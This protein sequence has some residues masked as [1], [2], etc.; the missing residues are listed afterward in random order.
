[1]L[2]N[3]GFPDIALAG[4]F[5]SGKDM[6]ADYLVSRYWY[7]KFAFGNEL[8]RYAHELFDVDLDAKPRELYQWFGQTMRERDPDI[9]VRKCFALIESEREFYRTFLEEKVRIVVTD[10][11]Q[12]NEYERCKA[13][14]F[15]LI[16]VNAADEI[17]LERAKSAGDQ[18]DEETLNHTTE[19]YVDLFDVDY[20]IDNNGT[21]AELFSQ[22]DGI[23]ADV[24]ADLPR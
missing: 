11:R 6:V 20:D 14:G 7:E 23:M 13:E 21:P 12:M 8:K 17:R 4:K 9:W 5:R 18:F 19:K 10:V 2:R 15:I 3:E 16:R 22:L 24:K 1:M